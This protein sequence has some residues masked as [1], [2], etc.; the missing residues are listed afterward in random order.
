MPVVAATTPDPISFNPDII[1]AG[2][3]RALINHICGLVSYVS[4]HFAGSEGN[5]AHYRYD[6]EFM[7]H[8]YL[9]LLVNVQGY[10]VQTHAMPVLAPKARFTAAP[11][12][13]FPQNTAQICCKSLNL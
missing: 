13:V 12:V 7:F 5:A 3:Y 9:F 8:N 10:H 4:I 1:G 6:H 11:V 2:R